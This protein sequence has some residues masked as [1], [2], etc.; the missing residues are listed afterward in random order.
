[1][2]KKIACYITAK[3]QGTAMQQA[4]NIKESEKIEKE[5]VITIEP[6]SSFQEVIGFGGALTEAAAVNILSL[7]PQ[8]QEEVLRGYFDPENGLGYKLCRIHMNS[9][10]F[11]IST[12]SCDDVEG[13]VELKHFNI[14][15]DKKMIILLLKR[16]KEYCEDLKILVSPWSPPAWM[17]TNGDMCHGGKLKEEYKKTWARFFCKFIKAY[18]EE[19]IDIWAVTVQNEPMATQVW[20][21]CIYTAEEERDFVKNYLGPTLEEEGLSHVKILVWDH[22]KDII[23]ERAKTILSDRE[24]AKYVWGVAFHWYGGDHFDQLK[25]IKEEFPD[26][27]LVFTEGCQEGGVKP[28]SWELGERYAH[29]IIG[30]F[31]SYTI[32][33]MDWNMVLDT[34]GGP[35]HVGNFCDAPIIVDTKSKLIYYQNAYYYIGHFSKFIKPGARVV[36]SSCSDARLE[37]LA[38]KNQDDTLAVVVL[39]KNPEEIE[40]NM[41]IEDKI[42]YGKSPARS[43][44]TIVLGK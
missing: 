7:L 34:M 33:F 15:R 30:D 24:A 5:S 17:K 22:N 42:F 8:Q 12:Y 43:I 6:S 27:N 4:D 28:G 39:N 1:M 20:E 41:V 18:K 2:F 3:D 37:V 19:E 38:A 11:C 36:R 14:E 31:N 35:N 13:D 32:G 9:C 21:S 40:F 29:E 25:K 16:I 10:D 23:Y 44:S 26:V